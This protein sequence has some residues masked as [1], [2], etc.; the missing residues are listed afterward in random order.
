MGL[1]QDFSAVLPAW[2]ERVANLINESSDVKVDLE[3]TQFLKFWIFCQSLLG[4]RCHTLE[5]STICS[6]LGMY[7][8]RT[9]RLT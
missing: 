3:V 4:A 5:V 8:R 7:P 6:W 2:R 1:S 9:R